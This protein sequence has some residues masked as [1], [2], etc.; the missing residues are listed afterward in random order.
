MMSLAEFLTDVMPWIVT[1]GAV[2]WGILEKVVTS[3]IIDGFRSDL[4][5]S[6]M[7]FSTYNELQIKALSTYYEWSSS[8]LRTTNKIMPI[9][10]KGS[11]PTAYYKTWMDRRKKLEVSYTD[12]KYVFPKSLHNKLD[13]LHEKMSKLDRMSYLQT[14]IESLYTDDTQQ[15]LAYAEAEDYLK[16]YRGEMAGFDFAA[17]YE[18]VQSRLL[19]VQKNIV[20][21]F[22]NFE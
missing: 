2:V 11:H 22:G 14:R 19:E 1:A 17:E 7:R 10:E 12:Y 16:E 9:V 15:H 5:K 21:K 13:E 3:R 6:E 4:K 20:D 8:L 18:L